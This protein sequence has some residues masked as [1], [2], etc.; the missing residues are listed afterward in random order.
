MNSEGAVY[1]VG[2]DP[3]DAA[4]NVVTI[5]TSGPGSR[6]GPGAPIVHTQIPHIAVVDRTNLKV[7]EVGVLPGNW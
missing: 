1:M 2:D 7:S 5:D 6:P 3:L 4:D